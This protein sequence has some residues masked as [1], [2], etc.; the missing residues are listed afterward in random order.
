ML[1]VH[2]HISISRIALVH[3]YDRLIGFLERTLLNERVNFVL[4]SKSQHLRNIS[5]RT[6][7][8][9]AKFYPFHDHGEDIKTRNLIFGSADLSIQI[10]SSV[11]T[12]YRCSTYLDELS[13]C[14]QKL[15]VFRDRHVGA[16][17]R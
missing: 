9:P 1:L 7:G 15:E 2:K 6:Y 5:W 3:I 10:Q 16:G 17:Y 13:V 11:Q 12:K 14:P 4:G 8:T